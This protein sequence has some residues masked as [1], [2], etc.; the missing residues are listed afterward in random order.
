M[1]KKYLLL[2]ILSTL[3]FLSAC[4]SKKELWVRRWDTKEFTRYVLTEYRVR[5]FWTTLEYSSFTVPKRKQKSFI[6]H[7]ESLDSFIG[8]EKRMIDGKFYE[9]W[10][11]FE[12]NQYTFLYY[13]TYFEHYVL[14]QLIAIVK[15]E[16]FTYR[17]PFIASEYFF[18]QQAGE[19]F[20]YDTPLNWEAIK[21][22]YERLDDEY[23]EI[24]ESEHT[25][26]LRSYKYTSDTSTHYGLTDEWNVEINYDA[27]KLTLTV[28]QDE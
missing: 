9:G 19:P 6:N 7:L 15:F 12:S 11:F 22:F 28:K 24:A 20:T 21:T 27:G 17:F 2:L 23:V 4:A 8:K 25:I 18:E 5:A 1:G 13:N 3:M 26:R 10:L 14:T 16:E